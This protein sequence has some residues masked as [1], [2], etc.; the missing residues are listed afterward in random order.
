ML[1][2]A[3]QDYY[4]RA[5]RVLQRNS[6]DM[7]HALRKTGVLQPVVPAGGMFMSVL[8][9]PELLK[10]EVRDGERFAERLAAEENVLAFPGEP[11]RM[12]AA[13]R[14]TISRPAEITAEAVQRICAFCERYKK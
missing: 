11:F 3:G 14:L 9:R 7:Y 12:P 1:K 2:G 4:D 13:L 5:V 6:I 10:E 8:L